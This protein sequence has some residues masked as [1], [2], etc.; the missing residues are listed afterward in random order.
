MRKIFA[1][2][3]LIM[4]CGTGYSAPLRMGVLSP[5]GMTEAELRA[6]MRAV[7]DM[8]G[9]DSSLKFYDNLA[10]MLM[11]LKSGEIDRINI[12]SSIGKYIAMRNEG[13]SYHKSAYN[14]VIGHMLAVP[15]EKRALMDEINSAI[16]NMK[17]DG[18][19]NELTR[20]YIL[21]FG[22]TDPSPV[23][24]PV[25]HGADT[26]KAAVTGDLPPLDCIL[27]DGTPAGFNTAFL[28]ELSRRI[29]RNITL[30]NMDTG[31]RASAL[32]SGRVDML[33]W[34]RSMFGDD[35][36]VLLPLDNIPG[37]LISDPYFIDSGAYLIREEASASSASSAPAE[38]NHDNSEYF[39]TSTNF[40]DAVSTDSRI[41]LGNYPTYQQTKENTCGP[42]AALT[43]LW[44]Y[45]VKDYTEDSL[46]RLMKTRPY[47]IGTNPKDMAA[48][49]E[50]LGWKTESNLTRDHFAE[51][52]DFM[53]FVRENLALGYPIMVE[54]V[55]WGGHWRV[56]IGYDTM[57]TDST[58]DDV[59]IMMDSYD[60]SDHKQD[61]YTVNNG[62]RFYAMWFDHSMLPAD[63]RDQ[64]FIIAHP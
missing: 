9:T 4:W 14:M 5:A 46:S 62:E 64:P 34:T 15:A 42:A 41:I 17:S 24:L 52:A 8:S 10:S 28:G 13:L 2:I 43:V 33:F 21:D 59:L 45:G 25:I 39:G 35:G 60:T 58:L 18:T 16:F 20:K 22:D 32:A 6:R 53:K 49:F 61:G 63:Q 12:P 50:K 48:F 36:K 51:Y 7:F 11:S 47:P 40:Y 23:E 3:M 44:Y 26:L 19:L 30:V 27:A 55:E 57:G 1:L 31:G 29:G 56:I 54:N 38:I 37:V